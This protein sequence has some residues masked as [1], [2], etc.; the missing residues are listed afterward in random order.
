MVISF[1]SIF[2]KQLNLD[3]K[4]KPICWTIK[5]MIAFVF[6]SPVLH[7][8]SHAFTCLVNIHWT[9]VLV[10]CWSRHSAASR[11]AEEWEPWEP[12][13]QTNQ[14]LVRQ[15]SLTQRVK[16]VGWGPNKQ[17]CQTK[18]T[19]LILNGLQQTLTILVRQ[20]QLDNTSQNIMNNV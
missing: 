1:S 9:P 7:M 13:S 20:K 5:K 2:Y 4:R 15:N 11:A 3:I 14:Y 6:I 8:P 12:G 10:N 16:L 18:Q 17:T 19:L